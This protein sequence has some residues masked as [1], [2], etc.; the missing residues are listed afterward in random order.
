MLGVGILSAFIAGLLSFI[1]P[2]VLPLVPVYLG[3]MTRNTIYKNEKLKTS[4]RSLWV[5]KYDQ[6]DS[7]SR[8][9]KAEEKA[10]KSEFSEKHKLIKQLVSHCNNH[11]DLDSII[12]MLKDYQPSTP[13]VI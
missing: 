10:V 12:E 13:S 6:I 3:I 11:T 8:Q 4:D 1:S 7:I 5:F 2:C 9:K